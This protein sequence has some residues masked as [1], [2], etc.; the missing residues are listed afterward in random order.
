M[1]TY[2]LG[3]LS[4]S[5]NG[6]GVKV[7]QTSIATG[8]TIHTTG[9]GYDEVQ[10][11]AVNEDTAI[12]TLTLGVAGTTAVDNTV[13]QP[14]PAQV[15]RVFLGKFLLKGTQAIKA[16]CDVANKVVIYGEVVTV[17]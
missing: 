14:I 11:W 13:T 5:T 6:E 8:T 12:R 4:G 2:A 15:G 9:S 10:L 17:S 7:A 16:A 3:K 1:S